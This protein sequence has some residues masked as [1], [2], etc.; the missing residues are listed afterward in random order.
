[1]LSSV[2]DHIHYKENI[3][4]IFLLLA[5]NFRW[6]SCFPVFF[7]SL[8]FSS[9]RLS[10]CTLFLQL[11]IYVFVWS[12]FSWMYVS[13]FLFY[14]QLLYCYCQQSVQD[15]IFYKENLFY[16]TFIFLVRPPLVLY[17]C[18]LIV[19]ICLCLAF[20]CLNVCFSVGFLL[21]LSLI[22]IYVVGVSFFLFYFQLLYCY[23]VIPH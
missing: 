15:H 3:K 17:I 11:S 6:A 16:L 19:N 23:W 12:L 18:F 10:F 9:L 14:F 8:F 1:M 13:F 4:Y 2:Q 7:S 5:C 20:V 21:C 22:I